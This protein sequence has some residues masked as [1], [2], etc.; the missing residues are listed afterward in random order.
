MNPD[1]VE[2]GFRNESRVSTIRKRRDAF[3]RMSGA[4]EDEAIRLVRDSLDSDWPR[5]HQMI[6]SS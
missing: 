3:R 1:R 6:L 4:Y 5:G 2:F